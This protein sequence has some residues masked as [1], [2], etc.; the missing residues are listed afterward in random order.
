MEHKKT[1]QYRLRPTPDQLAQLE[2]AAGAVRFVYNWGTDLVR[3]ASEKRE[4]IPNYYL[5]AKCLTHLKRESDKTWL[6]NAYNASLQNSLKDLDLSVKAFFREIKKK[7]RVGLPGFRK[8]GFNESVRFSSGIKHAK[9]KFYVPKIGFVSYHDS[10]PLQGR[11][12]QASVCKII[13]KWFINV[14]CD[15]PSEKLYLPMREMKPQDARCTPKVSSEVPLPIS[16]PH[17]SSMPDCYNANSMVVT[18]ATNAKNLDTNATD[19]P[20]ANAP[21]NLNGNA[22][23]RE[24]ANL[25]LNANDNNLDVTM[26]S[27]VNYSSCVISLG[28]GFLDRVLEV[29]ATLDK[30]KPRKKKSKR[31][32]N[33]V[34]ATPCT[35]ANDQN[36]VTS[37]ATSANN[38]TTIIEASQESSDAKSFS[39]NENQV[40][41]MIKETRDS[42]R[43]LC[44]QYSDVFVSIA[45]EKPMDHQSHNLLPCQK[46]S[47]INV[48]PNKPSSRQANRLLIRRQKK[49]SRSVRNSKNREKARIGLE[50]QHLKIRRR[51][52]DFLHKLSYKIVQHY[53]YITIKKYDL[54]RI[55]L[56]AYTPLAKVLR[57]KSW[58]KFIQYVQYKSVWYG[59]K[60]VLT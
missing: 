26:E 39:I 51:R 24:D 27:T 30:P 45:D 42:L 55:M 33:K 3:K 40:V 14:V 28:A 4:P 52:H 17:S 15:V 32:K 49:L 36:N 20:D 19:C 56:S 54:K 31:A 47:V 37:D 41:E 11:I 44:K 13:D 18:H 59:K 12:K 1:F 48:L 8:K 21:K 10:R 9:G 46:K 58:D 34:R 35:N 53:D 6:Q 22:T 29:D 5:L 7:N 25:V 57:E 16:L 2:Q 23:P 50:K 43:A 60:F 38:A